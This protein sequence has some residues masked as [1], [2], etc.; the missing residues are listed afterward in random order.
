VTPAHDVLGKMAE[1]FHGVPAMV[2]QSLVEP[3]LW[4][5]VAGIVTTWYLYIKRP[6][7]P[8]IIAQRSGWLYR[9]LVNNYYFD[10]V[11]QVLFADGAKRLGTMLWQLGDVKVIDGF[12][13]NGSGRV[14]AWTAS[15]IRRLQSGRIYHYAFMMIIGVFVL[16]TLWIARA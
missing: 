7:L 16:L 6:D 15:I 1:E 11:Y 8:G 5:A 3:P 9:L 4:L 10:K 12:F 2:L 14:V 13:V